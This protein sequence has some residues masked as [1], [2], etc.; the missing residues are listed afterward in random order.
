[1]DN[2]EHYIFRKLDND[3]LAIEFCEKNFTYECPYEYLKDFILP[4]LIPKEVHE[5]NQKERILASFSN[6]SYEELS[7]KVES[8]LAEEEQKKYI[9]NI[10]LEKNILKIESYDIDTL[11][12]KTSIIVVEE[13]LLNDEKLKRVLELIRETYQNNK[14]KLNKQFCDLTKEND[15]I[16]IAKRSISTYLE[17]KKINLTKEEAIIVDA[18]IN[19]DLNDCFKYINREYRQNHPLKYI[20]HMGLPLVIDLFVFG[21]ILIPLNSVIALISLTASLGFVSYGECKKW[22]K[23]IFNQYTNFKR[24][25]E[26]K[27]GF[28]YDKDD[29]KVSLYN[30]YEFYDAYTKS[31][32]NTLELAYSKT[33]TDLELEI[34]ALYSLLDEYKNNT[35]LEKIYFMTSLINIRKQIMLKES[36]TDKNSTLKRRVRQ[37][38]VFFATSCVKFLTGKTIAMLDDEKVNRIIERIK[39]NEENNHLEYNLDLITQLI[40]YIYTQYLKALAHC[41]NNQDETCNLKVQNKEDYRPVYDTGIILEKDLLKDSENYE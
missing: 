34:R 41:Y 26:N 35:S 14:E 23:I 19:R 32:K 18:V 17:K 1:M 22:N 12:L 2:I 39:Q 25:L 30:P 36:S 8:L 5:T 33:S 21:S 16:Q 3:F 40:E 28:A 20:F 4:C 11:E 29:K 15:N 38:D 24:E 9:K 7:N 13:E 6:T 10:S 27:Y 37:D 31:I